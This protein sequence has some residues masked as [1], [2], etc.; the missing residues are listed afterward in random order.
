MLIHAADGRLA[1]IS[2]ENDQSW[3]ARFKHVL[4]EMTIRGLD[5]RDSSIAKSLQ[6]PEP[7]S[8][9]SKRA[10][11]VHTRKDWPAPLLVKFGKRQYMAKLFLEGKGRISR[12]SY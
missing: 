10:L 6:M 2:I 1:F 5:Y 12:A 8:S 3:P 11:R 7:L 9:Q 4:E